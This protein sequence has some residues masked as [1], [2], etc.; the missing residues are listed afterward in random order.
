MYLRNY[1]FFGTVVCVSLIASIAATTTAEPS[2]R[3]SGNPVTFHRQGDSFLLG[4]SVVSAR[5]SVANGVLNGLVVRD[6]MHGTDIRVDDPFRILLKNGTILGASDLKLV[7]DAKTTHMTP[8]PNAPRV[9]AT[10]A[11]ESV[12]VA[13]ESSDRSVHVDWSIVLLE[14]SHYIRQMVTIAAAG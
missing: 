5:W 8:S 11:G 4:N 2:G 7:G 3:K 6:Q 9:A 10:L 12:A 14:C 1:R 13:M